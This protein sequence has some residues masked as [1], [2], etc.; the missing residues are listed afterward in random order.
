MKFYKTYLST[1]EDRREAFDAV[2]GFFLT[3]LLILALA[4][5]ML[6]TL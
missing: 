6:V 4:V 2:L 5:F 3:G 1:P